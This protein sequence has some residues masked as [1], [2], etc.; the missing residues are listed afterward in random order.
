VIQCTSVLGHGTEYKYFRY[1][2]TQRSAAR[3]A[4]NARADGEALTGIVAVSVEIPIFMIL[5]LDKFREC[6]FD[7]YCLYSLC[8]VRV[9]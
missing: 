8:S 1:F 7:T 6:G 2:N 9:K 5:R 3:N 4:E